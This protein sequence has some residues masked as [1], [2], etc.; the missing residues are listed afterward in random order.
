MEK[1][2]FS[3]IETLIG[4]A[5]SM[6]LITGTG[7]LL[8]QSL[9]LRQ[10][11]EAVLQTARIAADLV[12]SLRALPFDDPSLDAGEHEDAVADP[13]TKLMFRRHWT[14]EDDGP[15]IKDTTVTI[16]CESKRVRD[17]RLRV[18]LEKELGF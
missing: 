10:K 6:F 13:G 11:S 16:A 15:A 5:V 3:L 7:Q 17:V 2:G 18:R 4:L 14:V 9:R 1:K 12:E 8:L